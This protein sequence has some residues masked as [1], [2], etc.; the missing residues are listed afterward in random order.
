MQ[1]TQKHLPLCLVDTR[2]KAKVSIGLP[3]LRIIL[4]AQWIQLLK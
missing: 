3:L 2:K 1:S 4:A